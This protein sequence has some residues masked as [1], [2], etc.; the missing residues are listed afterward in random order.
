MNRLASAHGPFAKL[1][2]SSAKFDHP[3]DHTATTAFAPASRLSRV[4]TTPTKS[5]RDTA[6]FAPI[7]YE[8]GYAYPLVV[9][10]HGEG[11]SERELRQ[12]MPRVSVRNYVGAAVRGTTAEPGSTARYTWSQS[13]DAVDA[14][15]DAVA[16]CIEL[17]SLRRNIH[18]DR[19]FLVGRGAGGTMALRL[20]LGLGLP[21]A[22]AI[23]LGGA[24]P[25][26]N[27]LLARINEARSLPFMLMSC[28]ESLSYKPQQVA[29]DL[30]LLHA[31]GCHLTIHEYV[32][33]DELYTDM[34]DDID[35]WLMAQVCGAPLASTRRVSRRQV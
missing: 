17:A 9:W 22:G 4:R 13:P 11:S 15:T 28:R 35:Q 16:Q 29:E 10:L 14:A 3:A 30:R 12:V 32:C 20:A 26:G 34:F 2:F 7:H 25:R 21:V 1:A 33:G 31:A 6:L 18:P 19:I 23:S 24:V 5:P 27:G 8:P